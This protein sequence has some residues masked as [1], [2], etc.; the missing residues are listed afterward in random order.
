[1]YKLSALLVVRSEQRGLVSSRYTAS[2]HTGTDTATRNVR[3]R[4]A[5]TCQELV[6][7]FLPQKRDVKG[8]SIAAV[9]S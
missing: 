9:C 7:Y 2:Q 6:R 3:A 8:P 1:M 4:R 5:G